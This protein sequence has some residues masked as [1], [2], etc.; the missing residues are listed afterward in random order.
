MMKDEGPYVLEWVAHH[1]AVGFTD[2]LV[3]TNDCSDGTDAMLQRL[4]ALGLAWHRENRIPEGQRPQPSALNY[5]QEEPLVAE[6]DWLLVFDADEFVS[7]KYGDG[8]LDDLIAATKAQGANGIVITWRIFGSGGVH[9]WSRDPVTEQYLYA[10]PPMWNKGWGVKTLFQFDPDHWKLGIHRPKIKN[11]WLDT[12]WPHTIKWLNGAGRPMEDYFK[13]RGW[14]SIVRT[15]GYDWVQMNHYAVKS[16]DS[17]AIRKFRGNVN[18]KKDKYNTDYWALQDRNEVRD[19]T[20]LRY[21]AE[22]SRIFNALLLDPVLNRLHFAALDR[23]EAR[24][25]DFKGT[26]DYAAFV[27]GLKAAS[28]IPITQVE[29]KPPQARDKDKIA[30]MMSDVEKRVSGKRKEEL[31]KPAADRVLAPVDMY[32]RDTV[33]MSAEPPTEWFTNR[34]IELPGD[35]RLFTPVALLL[36][37]DGKFG[38]NLARNLPRFLPQGARVAELG[39]GC[40]FL[41]GF[42]SRARPDL[43]IT[44]QEAEAGRLAVLRRVWARNGIQAGARLRLVDRP[45]Q[46]TLAAF[47]G[48]GRFD[49]LMIDDAIITPAALQAAAGDTPPRQVMLI[50]RLL[51]DTFPDFSAWEALF[52]T[53]GLS[54]RL[55]LDPA[56]ALGFRRPPG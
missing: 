14:R 13:F 11:R 45:V 35:P 5:G 18:F 52:A 22:R 17:Y 55:P 54:E 49:T 15:I 8:T 6:S 39:A 25:A 24:L 4:E 33:D 47:L 10:A 38:R 48:A 32:V 21:H 2:I 37:R 16:I 1:L 42:L 27:D 19:D 7:I 3:Y 20:M 29:A 12:E 31:A 34:E 40:G 9:H 36:M 53:W 30:A 28:A 44:A 46:G 43:E 51:A 56:T 26:D 50:G 41:S 23:A